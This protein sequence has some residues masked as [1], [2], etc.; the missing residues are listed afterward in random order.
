MNNSLTPADFNIIRNMYRN[1]CNRCDM[2]N[3]PP[4][5]YICRPDIIVNVNTSPVKACNIPKPPMLKREPVVDQGSFPSTEPSLSK[6][7][8]SEPSIK[9]IVDEKLSTIGTD[10]TAFNEIP[11][12]QGLEP[13]ALLN[14]KPC[15]IR[16]EAATPSFTNIGVS[17]FKTVE[18]LVDYSNQFN[19]GQGPEGVAGLT[20]ADFDKALWDGVPVNPCTMTKEELCTWMFPSGNLMRGLKQKYDEIK[21]FCDPMKPTVAE[22]EFWNLEVI[23]HFR[24]LM[25][26]DL[27]VSFTRDLMYQARFSDERKFTD[28]WNQKYPDGVCLQGS[29][30]HCGFLW[31]PSE[32]DQ[33]PY[34]GSGPVIK[35]V[36]PAYEGIFGF[37]PK[38]SWFIQLSAI[39]KG[40]LCSEGLVYHTGPFVVAADL[41]YSFFRSPDDKVVAFRLVS[42]RLHKDSA[43]P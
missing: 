41:G 23:K 17:A 1:S 32:D 33:K 10:A 3:L 42:A 21:P 26:F 22:I 4:R 7:S 34:I 5:K 37:D 40:T 13:T 18:D 19:K 30:P 35:R 8:T 20:P 39:I 28:Y 12:T 2:A 29:G 9:N 25:G 27:S 6:S 31:L 15:P 24:R 14:D 38:L 36:A 43:C 11:V 16:G